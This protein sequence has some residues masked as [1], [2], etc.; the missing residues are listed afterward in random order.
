MHCVKIMNLALGRLQSP[1]LDDA[2]KAIDSHRSEPAPQNFILYATA[3]G[4]R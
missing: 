4:P 1:S 2:E 3:G